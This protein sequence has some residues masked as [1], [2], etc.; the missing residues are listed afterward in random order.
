MSL[1]PADLRSR[2]YRSPS[3]YRWRSGLS[4]GRIR[5][6][7]AVPQQES[8]DIVE[9]IDRSVARK[10]RQLERHDL[11]ID[12][13]RDRIPMS[14]KVY[15]WWSYRAAD[16]TVGDRGRRLDHIWVSRALQQKVSDFRIAR[17]AR[18]WERPSD[19]VPVTVALE[20]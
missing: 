4:A 17:D 8:V 5:R 6:A 18:G 15:T 12:V 7:V 20:L 19:H 2:V 16:W 3:E 13:A 1:D 10:R 9:L 11:R 14:E